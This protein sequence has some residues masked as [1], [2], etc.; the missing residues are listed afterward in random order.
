MIEYFTLVNGDFDP[1][2]RTF[3]YVP[4]YNCFFVLLLLPENRL[5]SRKCYHVMVQQ[6][7]KKSKT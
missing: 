2:F 7:Y 6:L 3:V 4:L 5:C 1:G